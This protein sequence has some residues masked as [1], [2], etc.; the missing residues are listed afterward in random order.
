MNYMYF[1]K[2][3]L[4]LLGL[5]VGLFANYAEGI[6]YYQDGAFDKAFPIIKKE[7]ER[8]DNKAAE[9]R[10]ASMYEKGEGTEVDVKQSLFWYKKAAARYSFVTKPKPK[11]NRTFTEKLSAQIGDDEMKAG[12][13]FKLAHI[14]AETPEV[15]SIVTSL[16]DGDFFGLKPYR[17]N[18]ILPVSYSKDKPRRVSTTIPRRDTPPEYREY[19]DNVEVKFQLSFKK[20]LSYNLFGLHEYITAAYSQEV[21]W[22]L[23]DESGPF[24][25][26]NYR[27]EIFLTLPSSK[28]LND[29]VGL[30][31]W[32]MG[33]LH[34]SNGQEGYR[35]RSWNRLYLTGLFQWDNLFLE[36][37]AWYRLPEDRKS[38]LFYAQLLPATLLQTQAS[39]DDNPYI[40]NYLGYGDLKF[41]YLYGKHKFGLLL[42][43][44]FSTN[45]N[46]S[47]VEFSYSYPFFGSP[48]TSWYAEFFNGYGESLIDY[49]KN[50]TK[51][52]VGFS[53]STSIF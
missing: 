12:D 22:Q 39:G 35:S 1:N 40:S 21:W 44:N 18:F 46:R 4:G 47:G 50:V 31:A 43:N 9:Y 20:D 17:T 38:D 29:S 49:N 48:N 10:L 25:E 8:G 2:V 42:R 34:E 14:K 28:S 37:R 16:V 53:L 5:S 26:T 52:S 32:K 41:G 45:H 7:A 15:K 30:K 6:K 23:Y 51:A 33:F 36:A 19:N 13:E 27:P 24:R 11:A 3:A